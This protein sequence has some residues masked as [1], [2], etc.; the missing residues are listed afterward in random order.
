MGKTECQRRPRPP[1][2]EGGIST[3]R[4]LT[5]LGLA[6]WLAGCA[7][8]FDGGYRSE[9]PGAAAVASSPAFRGEAEPPGAPTFAKQ[10][11][12][13]DLG[14]SKLDLLVAEAMQNNASVSAAKA[15]LRQA[16]EVYAARAGSTLYPQVNASIG[17]QRQRTNLSTAG[18]TGGARESSLYSAALGAHYRL[19]LAGENK[20]ILESLAARTDY[21]RYQLE[22]ARLALAAR[23]AL[24]AVAQAR[25][26]GQS[27][28]LERILQDQEQEIRLARERVRLGQAATSELLVLHAEAEATRARIPPL[29]QEYERNVHMMATLVGRAPDAEG[30]PTFEMDD[31]ALSDAPRSVVPSELVRRRPD[32]QASEALLY[33]AHAEFGAAVARQ[34]PQINLSASLGT[35][36]LTTGALF[37]GGATVWSLLGQV[38]QPLFN[39]GLSAE[40]RAA[41]AAF[42]AAAANYQSVVLDGLRDVADAL[43]ASKHNAD[44][45]AALW[46]ADAAAQA[47]LEVTRRQLSLGAASYVELLIAQQQSQQARL[48]LIGAGAQRLADRIALHQ[49]LGGASS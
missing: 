17:A 12:W 39:P 21:Q 18:Q 45:L 2:A 38:T 5:C 44:V 30:L 32:I 29:R 1:R 41:H 6:G 35:Q 36:A 15:T 40:K 42:E 47:A 3:A 31:F 27:Q 46:Q 23:I 16:E 8:G 7:N 22:A 26:A 33:A 25:L 13:R 14:S 49:S 34:Y 4:L 11:W 43:R 37:G 20:R 9:P 28:T 24:S 19:D 48:N 10:E